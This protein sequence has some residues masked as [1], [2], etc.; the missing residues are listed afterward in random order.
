MITEEVFEVAK[1]QN[2]ITIMILT[3]GGVSIAN[4]H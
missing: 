1:R 3:S 4:V 2:T